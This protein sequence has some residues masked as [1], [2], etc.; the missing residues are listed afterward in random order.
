MDWLPDVITLVQNV[1]IPGFIVIGGGIWF[2]RVG[3]PA[4]VALAKTFADAQTAM[5]VALE[6]VADKLPDPLMER[7]KDK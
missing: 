7:L 2:A 6:A 5:A 1:G 4:L 3:F